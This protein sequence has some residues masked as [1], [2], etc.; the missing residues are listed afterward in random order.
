MTSRFA[1]SRKEPRQQQA[2]ALAARQRARRRQ[3]LV[4]P[5]QEIAQISR[6]MAVLAAD[7]H[8][9]VAAVDVVG[10]RR[11]ELELLTL[12]VVVRRISSR[13]PRITVAARRFES[14]R[15]AA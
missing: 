3:Q 5:E 10:D 14:R 7:R 1:G 13:A 9:R 11:V 4:G 8:E 6:D 12:L 2:V 15:A